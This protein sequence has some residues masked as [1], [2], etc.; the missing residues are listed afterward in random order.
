MAGSITAQRRQ[1]V[2]EHR[3]VEVDPAQ[4][5]DPLRR[6]H[7]PEARPLA[8]EHRRVERAPAQVVHRDPSALGHPV[9][10]RV[11]DRRRLRL[12]AGARLRSAQPGH[13]DRLAQQVALE[14][15]PVRRVGH[16]DV[17]RR[18]ALAL[19]RDPHHPGQQPR[20]QRL[21]RERRAAHHQRHRVTDPA[22]EL[23]DHPRRVGATLL[24]GGLADHDLAVVAGRTRPRA[25]ASRGSPGPASP[26][27]RRRSRR[28]PCRSYRDRHPTGS[29]QSPLTR[30]PDGPAIV[31]PRSPAREFPDHRSSAR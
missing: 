28:R 6:P 11:R 24:L 4:V 22:L 14:R 9:P 23:P 17:L 13:L 27:G 19:R 3:L 26:P 16:A 31:E 5:L 10:R 8:R 18:A 29:P 20:R 30:E 25:P 7:Q 15:P 1:D 12:G 2:P 21:R